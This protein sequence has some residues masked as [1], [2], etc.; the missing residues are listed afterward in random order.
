MRFF[1]FQLC[2]LEILGFLYFNN[3]LSVA[4]VETC[5]FSSCVQTAFLSCQPGDGK[6]RE[7]SL[8]ACVVLHYV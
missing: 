3:M 4:L 6:E 2:C 7:F 8:A 1:L 5:S